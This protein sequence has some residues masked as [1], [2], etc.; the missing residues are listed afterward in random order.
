MNK[1]TIYYGGDKLL[2]AHG[3]NQCRLLEFAYRNQGWHSFK[4]DKATKNA[5]KGL[6]KRGH[7]EVSWGT[8]QFQFKEK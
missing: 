8:K 6:E 2:I 5:L 7:L 1:L 3:K 4:N